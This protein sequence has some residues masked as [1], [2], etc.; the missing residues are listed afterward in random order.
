[1]LGA[2]TCLSSNLMQSMAKAKSA[3]MRLTGASPEPAKSLQDHIAN[4]KNWLNKFCFM[5]FWLVKPGLVFSESAQYPQVLGRA[6]DLEPNANL[7]NESFLNRQ[8]GHLLP[9]ILTGVQPTEILILHDFT[10]MKWG[11]FLCQLS[12]LPATFSCLR[13]PATPLPLPR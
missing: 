6:L 7:M 5:Y 9:G 12:Q 4:L 13:R 8:E 2:M 1:M 10:A 3:F 11:S